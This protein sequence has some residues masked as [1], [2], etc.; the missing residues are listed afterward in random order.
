MRPVK[1]TVNNKEIIADTE[2]TLLDNILENGSSERI[3]H[4]K[5]LNPLP[6]TGHLAQPP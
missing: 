6:S 1:I 4:G 2:K 3:S 5:R